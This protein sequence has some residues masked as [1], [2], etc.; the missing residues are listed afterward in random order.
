VRVRARTE[1]RPNTV[2]VPLAAVQEVQ[3]TKTVYVVGAENS[4]GLR[5]SRDGARPARSSS[6]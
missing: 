2:L 4:V 5:T 1:E 3:A 6:C